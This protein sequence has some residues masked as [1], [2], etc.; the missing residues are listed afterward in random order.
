LNVNIIN[1]TI[2]SNDTTAS[3]GMLFNTLQ[4][5]KASSQGPCS[6][7]RNPDGTCPNAVT[8]STR[9]PAGVAAIQN[10]V[11][12]TTSLPATVVCPA[13]HF[14]GTNA[15]NANCRSVSYPELYNNVIWQNRVFNISV[16][17]LGTGP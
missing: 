8:A 1:N 6:V 15:T 12:L 7:P 17:G 3:S 5:P 2:A 10:S 16:G 14:Q 4:A 9:Q 11:Q 13:N